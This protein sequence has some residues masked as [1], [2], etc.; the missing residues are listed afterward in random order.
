MRQGWES[1]ISGEM[2]LCAACEISIT[3]KAD[4]ASFLCSLFSLI[5]KRQFERRG[6]REENKK[7]RQFSGWNCRF[8]LAES[9]RFELTV[10]R[11]ITSF[12]DWLL[13]P[14][15]Q[16]SIGSQYSIFRKICQAEGRFLGRKE[17]AKKR[18]IFAKKGVDKTG[19]SVYNEPRR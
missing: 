5:W 1:G 12:Q 13:K 19:A 10:G 3:R 17:P 6:K 16:L 4:T 8:F 18:W 11:P 14:L 9:V 2:P 15:G 7:K